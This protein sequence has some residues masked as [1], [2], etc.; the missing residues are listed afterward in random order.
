MKEVAEGSLDAKG[1]QGKRGMIKLKRE[2]LATIEA[3]RCNEMHTE[4]VF[5]PP[6]IANSLGSRTYSHVTYL[7]FD[8]VVI[9]HRL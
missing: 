6:H 2:A 5:S 7:G 1:K 3:R 9:H 8:I 4:C